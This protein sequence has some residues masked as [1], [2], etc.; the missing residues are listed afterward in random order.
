MLATQEH[1]PC[2][3][4]SQM[5]PGSQ[6]RAQ[7]NMDRAQRLGGFTEITR[8]EQED[9]TPFNTYFLIAV[10]CQTLG[11]QQVLGWSYLFLGGVEMDRDLVLWMGYEGQWGKA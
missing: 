1:C 2:G 3:S 10:M 4:L 9:S 7:V 11:Q 5:A 6:P 8:K